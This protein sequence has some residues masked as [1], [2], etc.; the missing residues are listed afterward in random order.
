MPTAKGPLTMAAESQKVKS[1]KGIPGRVLR[2][3]VI[4]SKIK[5]RFF[6]CVDVELSINGNLDQKHDK[7]LEDFWP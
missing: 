4:T 1:E 7:S 2:F 6:G 3:D 5:C